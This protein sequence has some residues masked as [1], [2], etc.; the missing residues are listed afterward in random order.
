MF[1]ATQATRPQTPTVSSAQW[2]A[3]LNECRQVFPAYRGSLKKVETNVGACFQYGY[4]PWTL[5]ADTISQWCFFTMLTPG[6]II[7]TTPKASCQISINVWPFG[8]FYWHMAWRVVFRDQKV[9][10][11][12]FE[13]HAGQ[14]WCTHTKKWTSKHR[15]YTEQRPPVFVQQPDILKDVWPLRFGRCHTSILGLNWS[16]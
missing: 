5:A 9:S 10:P 14:P 8:A 16:L 11:G 12:F 7:H 13:P 2:P 15:L 6:V 3:D 4:T 1:S